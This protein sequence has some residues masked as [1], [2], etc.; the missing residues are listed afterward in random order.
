[1]SL[2]LHP[3]SYLPDLLSNQGKCSG[4]LSPVPSSYLQQLPQG[5]LQ[6]SNVIWKSEF[7]QALNVVIEKIKQA[8]SF[9]VYTNS[10]E[11]IGSSQ[12]NIYIIDQSNNS[13]FLIGNLDLFLDRLK[14]VM[15]RQG[16]W[17]QEQLREPLHLD[18]D[19]QLLLEHRRFTATIV[20]EARVTSKDP[21][22]VSTMGSLYEAVKDA[23]AA[24]TTKGYLDIRKGDISGQY[25][26]KTLSG[27]YWMTSEKTLIK[28]IQETAHS[29]LQ[30]PTKV[31]NKFF[32]LD[33]FGLWRHPRRNFSYSQIVIG[34][35]LA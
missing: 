9:V 31:N 5:Q 23:F 10:E 18:I 26:F 33:E 29:R 15:G 11:Y 6:H 21:N 30:L 25:I 24:L 20:E 7:D 28:L 3:I 16:F 27:T 12:R 2:H 8:R 19:N 4:I 35:N 14:T 32:D 17:I 13:K 34:N 1:M 22:V